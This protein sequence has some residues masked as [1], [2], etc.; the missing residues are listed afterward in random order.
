MNIVKK[1]ATIMSNDIKI[2][3]KILKSTTKSKVITLIEIIKYRKKYGANM[4]DYLDFKFYNMKEEEVATYF[5]YHMNNKLIDRYNDKNKK[6]MFNNKELFDIIFNDYLG[7]KWIVNKNVSYEEFEEFIKNQN[8]IFYKKIGGESGEGAKKININEYNGDI[9]KLYNYVKKL[10]KGII[11]EYITS[12]KEIDKICD[13]GLSTFRIL[14]LNK[15]GKCIILECTFMM[16]NGSIV[17]NSKAMGGGIYSQV[18]IDKG[19]LLTDGVDINREFH[20]NHPISGQEIKGFQVPYWEEVKQ[21]INKI[22]NRVP[23]INYIGWD[24]AITDKGP[25]V[26][27]GNASWPSHRIWQKPYLREKK[28]KKDEIEAKICE[29]N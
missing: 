7:R 15:N 11:E 24:I 13:T 18:D 26:I 5:T 6:Y 29:K 22:Y 9:K 1:A 20:K 23:G 14:T 10:D 2:L 27:E 3:R 8:F 16:T 4:E 25:I 12:H 19:I 17:N 28:G 21:L